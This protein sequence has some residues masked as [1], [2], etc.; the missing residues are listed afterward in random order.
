MLT[1]DLATLERRRG[2]LDQEVL[3]ATCEVEGGWPYT[4]Y[5]ALYLACRYKSWSVAL[6]LLE[7]GATP[8]LCARW[9]GVVQVSPLYMAALWGEAGVVEALLRAGVTPGQ[10][11]RNPLERKDLAPEVRAILERTGAG[12]PGQHTVLLQA[13]GAQTH[14]R[15]T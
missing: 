9:W 12:G 5:T 3:D 11:D 2:E 8:G 6:L 1:G 15:G 10:G 4:A 13:R 14:W 7:R